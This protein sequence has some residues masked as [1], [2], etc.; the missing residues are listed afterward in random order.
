VG[1]TNPLPWVSLLL[2]FA[3]SF[4]LYPALE[5]LR[6]SLTNSSLL[7]DHYR[8]TFDSL[9]RAATSGVVHDSL[10]VTLVFVV[11]TVGLQLVLGLVAAL[12]LNRGSG[13]KLR[14]TI[15]VRSVVLT[16]WIM[17]GIIIG[18]VWKLVLSEASYGM[19]NSVVIALRSSPIPFLSDRTLALWT[20]IV[21][22][23]WRGTAF[24]MIL[25]YARMQ[26]I[27]VELYEA[28]D[29]DGG[30]V[31]QV[32]WH[33]TLPQLRQVIAISLVLA[34]IGNMNRFDLL[35]SLT[36]GGPGRATEVLSLMTFNSL[37]LEFDLSKA[38][39]LGGFMLVLSLTFTLLYR[40]FLMEEA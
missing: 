13:R 27:P 35:L 15:V 40:R 11:V 2:V 37:F 3:A 6:L 4:Y 20:L 14:G 22:A 9:K 28:A 19:I 18:V 21:A 10:R 12:A 8:Y 39:A 1:A 24:T 29:V 31:F 32:F 30:S 34:T 25:L 36:A 16:A 5:V 7:R 26:S 38:S 33:V 23:A 17:P